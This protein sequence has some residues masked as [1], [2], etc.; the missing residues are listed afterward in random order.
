M[1]SCL[2]RE[3]HLQAGK[4]QQRPD[5][6]FTSD[7]RRLFQNE[8]ESMREYVEKYVTGAAQNMQGTYDDEYSRQQY[9]YNNYAPEPESALREEIRQ[10]QA[11]IEGLTN[12]PSSSRSPLPPQQQQ[13]VQHQESD[14]GLNQL[15]REQERMSRVMAQMAETLEDIRGRNQFVATRAGSNTFEEGFHED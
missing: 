14:T 5:G 12:K 10:L 2:A 1:G 8:K 15:K 9:N 4:I 11:A 3:A 13:Y 6:L 7:G